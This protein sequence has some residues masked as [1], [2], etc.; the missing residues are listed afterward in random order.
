MLLLNCPPVYDRRVRRRFACWFAI[1][2]VGW[3]ASCQ[4]PPD[5]LPCTLADPTLARDVAFEAEVERV[6]DS[7]IENLGVTGVADLRGIGCLRSLQTLSV[8]A[9][10]LADLSPLRGNQSLTALFLSHVDVTDLGPIGTIPHLA[11]LSLDALFSDV[12]PLSRLRELTE[13]SSHSPNLPSL[14]GLGPLPSLTRLEV[15]LA[16]IASLEGIAGAPMLSQISADSSGVTSAAGLNDLPSLVSARL[17]LVEAGQLG[18]P[19]TDAEAH[20]HLRRRDAARL[21]RRN[22]GAAEPDHAR[23]ARRCAR[24]LQ[25]QRGRTKPRHDHGAERPGDLLA[26]P[27]GAR[28]ADLAR[29]R[30]D[31]L[32]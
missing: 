14:E 22:G 3:L 1:S 16:P 21:S 30:R 27:A 20:D 31:R 25:R 24:L 26:G 5:N 8:Q 19:R 32:R 9:S 18:R 2:G 13:L 6:P 11:N 15:D 29:P 23:R 7:E 28:R 4:R 10:T 12:S 17:R